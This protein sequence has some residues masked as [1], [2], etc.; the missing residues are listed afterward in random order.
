LAC[1]NLVL[2]VDIALAATNISA[3]PSEHYAWND[4]IGWIDFYNGGTGNV[5][6]GSTQLSGYAS[7]SL[8]Q[9]SLD[10]ATTPIGSICG[11]SNYKVTN[12]GLGSLAGYAWN[13]AVGWISFS[14]VNHGCASS[15]YGVAVSALTGIFSNYAWNDLIGWISFNCADISV[16][17]VS[18]YKVKT[19]WSATSTAATLDSSTYDTGV[20]TGAQLVS[21][22]YQGNVPS[23]TAVQF[24]FATSTSSSG[25]WSY[26]GPDGTSATYYSAAANTSM[27]LDYSAHVGARYF[28]YRVT[29]ISNVAQTL[30]PRIDDIVV[31][32]TP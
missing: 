25:P 23:G 9:V 21:V 28:R 7:S 13:D 31:S 24:Q 6:V 3:T 11:T 8:A 20:T 16:C 30:T 18:D 14:C 29:L 22:I 27:E 26:A 32:W 4:L 5:N 15:T 19:S 1:A 10:C 2:V 12:D 17:G